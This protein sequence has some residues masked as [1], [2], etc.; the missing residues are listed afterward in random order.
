M[1]I[2]YYSFLSSN[3]TDNFEKACEFLIWLSCLQRKDYLH[4]SCYFLYFENQL[5]TSI[6]SNSIIY[7]YSTRLELILLLLISNV[8][9][10][11]NYLKMFVLINSNTSSDCLG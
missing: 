11:Y 7:I 1:P 9:P 2:N 6:T 4:V 10:R 5:T 8:V 3:Y